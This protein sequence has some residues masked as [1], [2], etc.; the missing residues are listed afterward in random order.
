MMKGL[1]EKFGSTFIFST[2]DPIIMKR[3]KRLITLKDGAIL[4]DEVR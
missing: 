4:E 2:H 1:N 3:A